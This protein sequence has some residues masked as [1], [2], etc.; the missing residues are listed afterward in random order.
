VARRFQPRPQDLH[1]AGWS[2]TTKILAGV[3][4]DTSGGQAS[5]QMPPRA[6]AAGEACSGEGLW[7]TRPLL[8]GWGLKPSMPANRKSEG[9]NGALPKGALHPDAAAMHITN[10]RAMARPKPAPSA[11][12]LA[13]PSTWWKVSKHALMVFDRDAYPG[14]ATQNSTSRSWWRAPT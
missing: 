1:V 6:A 7:S 8:C 13:E 10:R 2:S 3:P 11:S 4:I 5:I 14:A 12:R 9:K